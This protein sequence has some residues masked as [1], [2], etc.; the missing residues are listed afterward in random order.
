MRVLLN[1]NYTIQI[2]YFYVIHDLHYVI[3][4]LY[5]IHTK[6]KDIHME[7]NIS[8]IIGFYNITVVDLS[9]K[10]GLSRS[11]ISNIINGG[12]ATKD[13]MTK[14]ADAIGH[15]LTVDDIF[16][17]PNVILVVQNVKQS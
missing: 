17:A 5:Y 3:P 7:N 16:F 12:N 10:S 6:K 14:I 8:K 13:T 1:V 11:T 2:G 9:K 15:G 4:V